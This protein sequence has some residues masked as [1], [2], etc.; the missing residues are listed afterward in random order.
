MGRLERIVLPELGKMVLLT[1]ETFELAKY[2]NDGN[3]YSGWRHSYISFG[4]LIRRYFYSDLALS[5]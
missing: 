5:N 3:L 4:N 1:K 2:K